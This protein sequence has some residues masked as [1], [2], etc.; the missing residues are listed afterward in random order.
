[1]EAYS[2]TNKTGKFFRILKE[3]QDRYE[4]DLNLSTIPSMEFQTILDSEE[5]HHSVKFYGII[6]AI[7]D[8]QDVIKALRNLGYEDETIKYV[9][10]K[11]GE[12]NPAT[13]GKVLPKFLKWIH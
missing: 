4:Q 7:D 10:V 2:L 9:E 12:H 8:T 3:K 13:W 6:D 5:R 1:M 11:G